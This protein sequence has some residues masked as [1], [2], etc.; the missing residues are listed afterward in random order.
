MM[1]NTLF[2]DKQEMVQVIRL[3]FNSQQKEAKKQ[4]DLKIL[5][6]KLEGEIH[7]NGNEGVS[8]LFINRTFL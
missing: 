5:R 7:W 4:K 3:W 6:R 2:A 8:L 1:V